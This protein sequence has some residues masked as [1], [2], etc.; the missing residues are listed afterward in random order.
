MSI[1][2]EKTQFVLF[3]TKSKPVPRNFKIIENEYVTISR[4][5]EIQYLGIVIDER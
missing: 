3:H 4:V 2:N 5:K 1:T